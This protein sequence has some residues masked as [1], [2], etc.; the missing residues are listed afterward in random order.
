MPLPSGGV[1][2]IQLWHQDG[3]S[4][5][6]LMWDLRLSKHSVVVA[7]WHIVSLAAPLHSVV[8]ED[9]LMEA[10]GLL[11]SRSRVPQAHYRVGPEPGK[12]I[13]GELGRAGV[14]MWDRPRAQ[15][16]FSGSTPVAGSRN[17]GPR[18]GLDPVLFSR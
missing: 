18:L 6:P 13:Q 14:Y 10:V 15:M 9:R 7:V 2:V 5:P 3:I 4:G 16:R 12:G 17:W 8:A 11:D 1:Q